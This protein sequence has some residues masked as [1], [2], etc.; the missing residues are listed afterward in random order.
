MWYNVCDIKRFKNISLTIV[1]IRAS[2]RLEVKV[3][4]NIDGFYD[5]DGNKLNPENGDQDVYDSEGDKIGT[6]SSTSG[7]IYGEGGSTV[8]SPSDA[9]KW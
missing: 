3:M 8:S 2:K 1:V 7:S 6:Y 4:S 9:R 5:K